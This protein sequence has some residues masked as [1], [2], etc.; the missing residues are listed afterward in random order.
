MRRE[1][2]E[3]YRKRD[4]LEMDG[5]RQGRTESAKGNRERERKPGVRKENRFTKVPA[6]KARSAG[7]Q[8]QKRVI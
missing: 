4:I 7:A 5:K 6:Q 2:G 3:R 8:T 1:R